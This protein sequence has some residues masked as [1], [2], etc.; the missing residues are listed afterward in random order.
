MGTAEHHNN[1]NTSK[2][3]AETKKNEHVRIYEYQWFADAKDD[4]IEETLAASASLWVQNLAGKLG[5]T[6]LGKAWLHE[7]AENAQF[8]RVEKKV[9]NQMLP[10]KKGAA[11][12]APQEVYAKVLKFDE[13]TGQL[14]EKQDK[15]PTPT[16]HENMTTVRQRRRRRPSTLP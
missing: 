11:V 9:Q 8:L 5:V 4:K 3:R 15:V 7:P 10:A 1:Q 14:L 2:K 16:L 13:A 6:M 12:A